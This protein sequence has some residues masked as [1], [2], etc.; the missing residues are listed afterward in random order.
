[1]PTLRAFLGAA[2][3][4]MNYRIV[5]IHFILLACIG[6]LGCAGSNSS[7]EVVVYSALDREFAD[8]ILTEFAKD[9]AIEAL[10]KFDIE[11]TKTVGLTNEIIAEAKRPQ[12][13]VFWN[14]EIL[15]TLRLEKLGL[16]ESYRPP[17][18][19]VFDER[20]RSKNGTWYGFAARARILIVNKKLVDGHTPPSSIEDLADPQWNGKIGI[21]K[22]LFGT[23]STQAAC[24][25]AVLGTEKAEDYFRRV[26]KNNAQVLGGNKRV[27]EMVAAGQLAFGLT[28]TDDAIIEVERGMPV[29]IVYPDQ[30][31][32]QIGTLFIPNTISMIKGCPHPAAAKKLIDF[33]LSP[34]VE[35]ELSQGAGAQIPLSPLVKSKA[36]VETPSTIKAMQ[37]DFEAA[38]DQWEIAARF[39]REE[40]ASGD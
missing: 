15:N 39:I 32:N 12:A 28:D 13:D 10:P 37:V 7:N 20:W 23:T 14:N 35:E 18:A 33:L 1:M 4:Q 22:P 8:P 11:S 21:A 26:K 38:A 31:L 34:K 5:G 24:L 2:D 6:C 19:E 40:F 3:M 16:L 30:G 29:E 36:R 9:T 27:A 17:A 25:F